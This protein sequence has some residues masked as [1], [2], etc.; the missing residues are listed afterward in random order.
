MKTVTEF[1]Y[2]HCLGGALFDSIEEV[3]R[4]QWFPG[5]IHLMRNR[6][7]MGFFRYGPLDKHD[8]RNYK[9]DCI[10]SIRQ[11]L[12]KYE[13]DGNL[14]YLIDI[15]NLCG[16]EYRVSN[17]PKRHFASVDDGIHVETE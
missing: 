12:D 11:R 5:F 15:A 2:Q 3:R 6:M 16:V 14:E 8:S 1:I 7:T 17:H 13:E 9:G 10:K 4:N